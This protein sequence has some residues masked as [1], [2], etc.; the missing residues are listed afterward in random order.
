MAVQL[1]S[2]FRSSAAYRVRIA[3]NL[4]AIPFEYKEVHLVKDGGEHLK[5]E[6]RKINPMAEVPTLVHNG[7]ALGQSMA[8]LQYLDDQWP[9]PKLFPAE[10]YEKARVIQVCEAI[11]SGIHPIQNLRVLNYLTQNLNLSQQQKTQWAAHWIQTGFEKLEDLLA[12][13]SGSHCLGG[14]LTAADLFL[15]PQMYNARRFNVD[16][17]PFP[18]LRRI[19][20]NCLKLEAFQKAKPEAQPDFTG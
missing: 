4:K 6:Y 5:E 2:Y 1:Y 8:I 7:K 13:L 14:Q 12:P 19:E 18:T 9:N 20:E 11:N 3:L 16:L 15:V 17:T 10:A